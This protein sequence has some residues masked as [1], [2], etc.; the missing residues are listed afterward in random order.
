MHNAGLG[1]LAKGVNRLILVAGATG[2][3]GRALVSR[4]QHSA[5]QVRC[6]AR[7]T[8]TLTAALSERTELVKGDV[9]ER[10]SLGAALAGVDTAFY[11]IHSM[12]AKGDFAERDRRGACNFAAAARQAR[13]RR[14]VYLGGL[15]GDNNLSAH[16]ASR[17]EVGQIFRNSGIETLEL[18]AS[19]IIGSGSLSFEMIRAMV[20]KLP[21]MVTPRW[22]QTAAQPIAIEDVLGYL[23]EAIEADVAGSTIFEIGGRDRVSYSEIMKAY[24]RQR[25]LHRWMIPVK[26]LTPYLSSLW[27]GL[28]TPHY[29]R[30][31]RALIE[32]IRNETVV[33][34]NSAMEHFSLRPCGVDEAIRKALTA[35]ERDFAAFRAANEPLEATETVK[36]QGFQRG[37]RFYD[38]Y[39]LHVK[40]DRERAF[41]PIQRIGGETGWYYATWLWRLRGLMDRAFGG[42]GMRRGRQNKNALA[43]GDTVD[44]WQVERY[45]TNQ[46]VRLRAEMRLPGRGWLQFEVC[47]E[48]KGTTICLTAIFEPLGLAGLL[49]WYGVFPVHQFM[50]RRM[51]RRLAGRIR[52]APTQSNASR[53]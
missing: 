23:V 52:G 13:V 43:V 20:E 16:L 6:L 26:M 36:R 35:E 45:E 5:Y 18:R 40:C 11:L 49:Y 22:V 31:G 46:M 41:E 34:D 21:V 29:V 9:L 39:W 48:R 2:Y 25:G 32:G 27:L 8:T 17:H 12:G 44:F 42:V 33:N 50:F 51:L 14:I 24:A 4:L 10:A 1:R 47:P 53:N 30:T 3:V 19:I 15:G 7:R 37:W 28:V 38:A